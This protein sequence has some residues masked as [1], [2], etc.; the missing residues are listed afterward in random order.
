M[1]G[2]M[3]FENAP[4][5]LT[6]E[7]VQQLLRAKRSSLYTLIKR[8]QIPAERVG[9]SYRI[10]KY[11]VMAFMGIPATIPAREQTE[12]EGQNENQHYGNPAR[13]E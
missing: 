13:E 1:Q 2:N 6:I 11:G 10:P 12:Q 7:E 8:K 5:V 9:N 3:T 4:D